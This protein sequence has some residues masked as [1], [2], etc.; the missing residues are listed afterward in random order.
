VAI[1]HHRLPSGGIGYHRTKL[2]Q[3]LVQTPFRSEF[4]FRYSRYSQFRSFNLTFVFVII[5]TEDD[6]RQTALEDRVRETCPIV[7]NSNLLSVIWHLLFR[8]NLN[9][10]LNL[11]YALFDI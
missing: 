10:N 8:F 3:A 2:L 5:E 11:L 4:V 1:Y 9:L 7:V 6:G